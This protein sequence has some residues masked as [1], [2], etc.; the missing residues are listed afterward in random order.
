VDEDG[1]YG[2]HLIVDH[3]VRTGCSRIGLITA[4]ENLMFAKY[5]LKGFMDSL[6]RHKI[7]SNGSYITT[8]DLTQ[9]DGYRQANVLLDLPNPPEAIVACNDLMAIG[10]MSA[11]QQRGLQVGVDIAITGFDDTSMSEHAHPPLTTVHQPVYKIGG[12]VCEMLVQII[13][14]EPPKQAK[15]VQKPSLVIR[16]SSG[17]SIG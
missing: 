12:R 3:L 4:P 10:A 5:R 17:G 16:Q 15:V 1:E 11:A 6:A 8:G 2:M 14:G 7:P 9:R 13:R